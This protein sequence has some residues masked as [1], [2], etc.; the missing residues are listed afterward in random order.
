MY[1]V[2]RLRLLREVSLRGTLAA[3]AE[4]LGYNA[5][6]V[7]HQLKL[8]EKEVGAPLLE[9]VG[10]KVRLTGEARILV[11]HAEAIF[12]HLEAAEAE[13]ALA[14]ESVSGTVR[15]A[16]FQ[17]AGHAVIPEALAELYRNYPDLDVTVAHI[18]VEDA[19]SALLARDF[20]LVLQEDYPGHPQITVDGAEITTAG[21]D[22]LWLVTG[23][24]RAQVQLS[25]MAEAAW[26]LEPHGTLARRWATAACR[27]AGFEPRVRF[28]SSDVLLH[29]RLVAEGLAVALVPGLALE[30][31]ALDELAVHEL[32]GHPAR[33]IA[34][35]IRSGSGR[36]PAIA[37]VR[38]A[39]AGQT[40]EKLA[41]GYPTAS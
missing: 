22:P 19:L 34:S 6:S 33:R 13:I 10:R 26:V 40:A 24:S 39:I 16:S 31:A 9:P 3:A 11:E 30:G 7:S 25:D 2:N 29:L 32:P 20:D 8:L 18:P 4:A 28:E 23:S 36:S 37:A 17:T 21:L 27:G 14:R 12:R 1:S 35:A 38:A 41:A 5:S 15:V